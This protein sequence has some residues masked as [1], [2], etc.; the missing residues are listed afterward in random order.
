MSSFILVDR[1]DTL[2]PEFQF[3]PRAQVIDALIWNRKG[4]KKSQIG[5]LVLEEIEDF[6]SEI[7]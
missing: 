4:W 1:Y 6:I 5:S 7:L 3:P 2:T